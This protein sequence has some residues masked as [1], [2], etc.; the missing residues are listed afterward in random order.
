MVRLRKQ[1][2]T[3]RNSRYAHQLGE[4]MQKIED[5]LNRNEDQLKLHKKGSLSHTSEQI[6]HGLF[7]VANRIDNVWARLTNL[8]LNHDGKDVKEVVD[9]RV[10]TDASIH[11]TAKDRLDY[12]FA[13]IDKRFKREVHVDDF[14]AVPDGKTDSTEAFKKAFG[15]GRVRVKAS[16]GVYIVRGIRI[17]SN[18]ALIGQGKGITTFKLHEDAPASTILLTNKDHSGNKNI[19]VDGFSLDW[20]RDRQGGM[21]ATGG[22]ASSALTFAKVHFGWVKNVQSINPGLHG[23]DFTAP[24]Y[25]ISGSNYTKDGCRYVWVENCE[26][27]GY[28][29]DG[30]TT[31]YSEYIFIDRCHC[32]NPSG[33]AHKEGTAN[34][35][36]IEIDDG[37]RN[38]WVN[39]SYTSGNIR[40]VE[41]K[42]HAQWPA[43]QNVHVSD[44]VSYR[45]VRSYD[46]RHIGHHSASDPQST[47]ARDVSFTNCV[48][49]EPVFNDMYKGLS[50]RALVVSAYHRVKVTNFTAIGNPSYD[51]KGNPVVA[52]QYKSRRVDINGLTVTGF[53]RASHDVRVFGGPQR[54]DDVTITNFNIENSAPIG[55]GIGGRVYSVKLMAGN[56]IHSN[57]NIGVYSPNTQTTIVGVHANGYSKAAEL[58]KKSHSKVPTRLKG[59]MVAGSTS[60][61][62]LSDSS[63]V[64]A[65]TGS[66]VANGPANSVIASR[67]GSSTEGSRQAVIASNNSHTKGNG[68]ARTILSSHNVKQSKSYTVSGGYNDLKWEISSKSGNITSAGQ[69]RGGSSLSDYAEYFESANGHEIPT[70]TIVTLK[71]EKIMPAQPGD[72]LLGVVSNTAA[73]VLGEST[74][75]WQGKY[76]RDRFGALI[77]QKVEVAHYD[78]EG[79]ESFEVLDLPMENP[80]YDS[81]KSKAYQSR[82]ERKE[83]HVIGLVGQVMV[84]IDDTVN[85]GDS[86]KAKN[87][88][89]TKG[90]SNWQVM[91][92]ET[93]YDSEMGYGIAK[94]FIR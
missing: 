8:V 21:R 39:G 36:G 56:L 20:N 66:C 77:N 13:K 2:D 34:S 33:K 51:Y 27:S 93:P 76:L 29:D 38:V 57:G 14:G 75:E 67:A 55:I 42:A 63:A 32:S 48:S 3:T 9:I 78:E 41:V 92:I 12:E 46:A 1:Y 45:D 10:A 40:G 7:T 5:Q 64:I 65:A 58:A 94:V 15:N 16:A 88:V 31:H 6:K 85:V 83:W 69:V 28:G 60:G 35:N 74:F 71:G 19:Y 80:A 90:Q 84:R 86:V 79:N 62:A 44:H 68:Y 43:A 49:I 91:N 50:P 4:D 59:G 53:K 37:S 82:A 47:T 87:G 89:A 22:I 23:F 70:G 26:A 61:H 30:I 52:I 17:P 72:Y 24:S 81:D 73:V 54:A 25:N 11:K 18:S